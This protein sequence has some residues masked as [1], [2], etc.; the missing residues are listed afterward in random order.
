MMCPMP[1]CLLGKVGR[2]RQTEA[3][4]VCAVLVAVQMVVGGAEVSRWVTGAVGI[5]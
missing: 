5:K 2:A 4:E 3:M 1:A